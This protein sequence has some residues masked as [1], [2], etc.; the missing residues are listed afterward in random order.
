MEASS[1]YEFK[2]EIEGGIVPKDHIL[3]VMKELE[4][5]II[6]IILA[7]YLVQLMFELF[8]QMDPTMWWNLVHWTL[9]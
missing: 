6:K 4:E 1:A 9:S 3:G 7:W 5:C 8:L 2:S